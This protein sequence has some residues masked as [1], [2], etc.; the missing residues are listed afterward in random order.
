MKQLATI[1]E[2]ARSPRT[3]LGENIAALLGELAARFSTAEQSVRE[4]AAH[5][6]A[7]ARI[8]ALVA[9]SSTSPTKLHDEVLRIALKDRSS[10]VR[11]LAT[12]FARVTAC[13]PMMTDVYG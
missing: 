7:H 11:T 1:V 2:C 3:P 9:I 5:P 8:N 6:K 12:C 10:K 13:E 4:M